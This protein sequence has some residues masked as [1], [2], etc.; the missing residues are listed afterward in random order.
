LAL[1][2]FEK[3]VAVLFVWCVFVLARAFLGIG[4]SPERCGVRVHEVTDLGPGS[5]SASGS[6]DAEWDSNDPRF[7]TKDGMVSDRRGEDE[8]VGAWMERVEE[9][10]GYQYDWRMG[11]YEVGHDDQGDDRYDD[12]YEH[13]DIS[14]PAYAQG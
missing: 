5:G 14:D 9:M 4:H 11:E 8:R 13:E 12:E 2:T 3:V 6:S 10:Y 7:R 1:S